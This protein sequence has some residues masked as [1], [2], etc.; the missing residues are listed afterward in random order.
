[1]VEPM[2][3]WTFF[4]VSP[5]DIASVV[6]AY[7][8]LG[9]A[10]I[11]AALR[12]NSLK[13]PSWALRPTL[14]MNLLMGA[15]WPY[16]H[17][18]RAYLGNPPVRRVWAVAV[19][20]LKISASWLFMSL[21]FFL[22][23]GAAIFFDNR[24]LGETAFVVLCGPLLLLASLVSPARKAFPPGEKFEI[25]FPWR[26]RSYQKQVAA[27]GSVSVEVIELL[28]IQGKSLGWKLYS[29]D[30]NDSKSKLMMHYVRGNEEVTLWPK[31]GKIT[32]LRSGLWP[33]FDDFLELEE[34]LRNHPKN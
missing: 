28:W 19:A 13:R 34:W 32:L 9:Q 11:L 33:G 14:V 31:L 6:I 2:T 21:M 20:L 3:G 15:T 4:M 16:G 27:D 23:F 29:P 7:G 1:M 24:L 5:T 8:F 17:V 25:R 12:T 26:R 22:A 10:D 30:R 18:S